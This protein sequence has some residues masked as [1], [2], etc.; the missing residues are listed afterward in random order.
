M[1]WLILQRLKSGDPEKRRQ[2]VESLAQLES[3][4]ALHGLAQAVND[5]D[6]LV[7]VAAVTALGGIAHERSTELLL[8]AFHDP[9]PQVRQAAVSHLKDDGSERVQTALASAIRDSDPGVRGRAARFLEQ[10][11]WH[12]RDIEDEV[13]LAIAHGQMMRAASLGAA[14]IQPLESVLQWGVYSQQA[15]VVEALGAI[16]DERVLKSLVRALRSPDHVVCL[17][18]IG[19]LTNA[20][21][22]GVVND[23]AQMLKHNDHRIR[24]AAVEAVARFDAQNQGKKFRELLRDPMWDVRCAAATALAKVKDPTTVDALLAVLKDQTTDVRC[25]AAASL[26]RIG[27][28][29]AIGPLVLALKD[30]ESE[31]RKTAAGALTQ[32]DTKWAESEAARKLA[33]ELRSALGSGDWAVRRAATYVLEQIGERQN[34]TVEEPNTEMSTPARRRQ[35]AVLTA[36][37]DL[38]YDADGDL[39]LAAAECLGRLGDARARSPLMTALTDADKS[40]RLA[41]AHALADLG[42]E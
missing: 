5:K 12:P 15:A 10:S 38:M 7:R 16:P 40:V 22:P 17:A 13:W 21:G 8:R 25:A 26:G 2:A 23:V 36:F 35:Q 9:S 1:L 33:P 24:T 31:V 41:A 27:D 32:I 30:D 18:A 19:A 42:V 4:R 28:A 20:G 11:G 3:P 39:R 29:R 34:S 14:A 6:A 37:T